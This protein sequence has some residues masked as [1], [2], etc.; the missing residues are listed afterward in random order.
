MESWTTRKDELQK[1]SRGFE[2]S[3]VLMTKDNWFCKFIAFVLQ[4]LTGTPYADNMKYFAMT[5]GPLIFIPKE[6]GG[7]MSLNKT[8]VHE[9]RHITQMKA[10]GLFI[11]PWIGLPLYTLVYLLLFFPVG[12]AWFRYRF[13]LDADTAEFRYLYSL[14]T[15]SEFIA[16]M[17]GYIEDRVEYRAQDLSDGT[18]GWAWFY[19]FVKRGYE[20]KASEVLAEK[21]AA[22]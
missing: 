7:D 21:L 12:L 1:F 15:G 10:F 11:H 9:C 18:Y 8:L 2:K 16:S 14:D 13:E 17:K 22:A 5:V 20:K 19:Y 3:A 4:I 6:W